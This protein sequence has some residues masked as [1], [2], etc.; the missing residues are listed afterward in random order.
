MMKQTRNR[1]KSDQLNCIYC[2]NQ[3]EKNVIVK[4]F[5]RNGNQE[6]MNYMCDCRNRIK[7]K[8]NVNGHYIV[9]SYIKKKDQIKRIKK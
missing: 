3:F 4:L 5:E 2:Q 9:Y 7:I 8:H 1:I 6:Q